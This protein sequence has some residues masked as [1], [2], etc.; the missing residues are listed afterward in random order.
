MNRVHAL[1]DL[2]AD[3]LITGEVGPHRYFWP[4]FPRPTVGTLPLALLSL[5][6]L[7]PIAAGQ[8]G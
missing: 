5:A 8:V 2:G 4:E 6:S 1:S 3:F 7:R